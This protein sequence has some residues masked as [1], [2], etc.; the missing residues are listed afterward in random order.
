MFNSIKLQKRYE[1][2]VYKVAQFEDEILEVL[3]EKKNSIQQL[4]Y[5]SNNINCNDNL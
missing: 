3:Y 1:H 2:A 4:V 5:V